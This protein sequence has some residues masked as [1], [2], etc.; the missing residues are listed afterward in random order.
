MLFWNVPEWSWTPKI[1]FRIEGICKIQV[2]FFFISLFIIFRNVYIFKIF[3]GFLFAHWVF[4][5]IL[6]TQMTENYST[7]ENVLEVE[8]TPL[9]SLL[10]QWSGFSLQSEFCYYKIVA[11]DLISISTDGCKGNWLIALIDK[12]DR[13]DGIKLIAHWKSPQDRLLVLNRRTTGGF[14][15]L[16]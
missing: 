10:W 13:Y 11:K 6:T 3:L 2:L 5:S 15:I 4:V 16:K 14:K 7:C 1:C 12:V 9:F 8:W